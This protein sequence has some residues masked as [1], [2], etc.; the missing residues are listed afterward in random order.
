[1]QALYPALGIPFLKVDAFGKTIFFAHKSLPFML[2]CDMVAKYTLQTILKK[3]RQ[4]YFI[5]GNPLH[6]QLCKKNPMQ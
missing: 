1:M 3:N 5:S 2:F 4:E 6:L